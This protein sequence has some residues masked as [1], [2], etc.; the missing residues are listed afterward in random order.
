MIPHQAQLCDRCLVNNGFCSTC[1]KHPVKIDNI[2]NARTDKCERCGQN[3]KEARPAFQAAPQPAFQAAPQPHPPSSQLVPCHVC[4]MRPLDTFALCASC[5]GVMMCIRIQPSATP[6]H[7]SWLG[8]DHQYIL[9][10]RY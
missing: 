8:P 3:P 7:T 9:Q 4:A 1:K 5:Q 2:T 6:P 10:C